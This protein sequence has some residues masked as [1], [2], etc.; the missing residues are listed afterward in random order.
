MIKKIVFFSFGIFL[1]IILG[2]NQEAICQTRYYQE[3]LIAEDIYVDKYAPACKNNKCGFVNKK[4]EFV[5]KPEYEAVQN[6]EGNYFFV[7]KDE[8]GQ[9]CAYMNKKTKKLLTEFKYL[10]C[11][12][13]DTSEGFSQGLAKVIVVQKNEELKTGYIDKTGREVIPPQ[14][15]YGGEFSEGLANIQVYK[16]GEIKTGYIN[17]KGEEVLPPIYYYGS[18]F[19]NGIAEVRLKPGA[20]IPNVKINSKDHIITPEKQSGMQDKFHNPISISL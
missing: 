9:K 16:K 7:C 11:G 10:G 14:Y 2:L 12:N 6:I 19:K 1:F 8:E 3:A 5:I 18:P 15:L 13:G 17:K 4:N 20:N